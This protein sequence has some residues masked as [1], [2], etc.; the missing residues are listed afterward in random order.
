MLNLSTGFFKEEG[1]IAS[2]FIKDVVIKETEAEQTEEVKSVELEVSVVLAASSKSPLYGL[3]LHISAIKDAAYAN[4]IRVGNPSDKLRS[5]ILSQ[6]ETDKRQY[7]NVA[8]Q[9]HEPPSASSVINPNENEGTIYYSTVKVPM[10]ITYVG[11][12]DYLCLVA[13]VSEGFNSPSTSTRS[14]KEYFQDRQFIV[15]APS[16]ETVFTSGRPEIRTNIF[17]L[18]KDFEGYGKAGDVWPSAVHNHPNKGLMAGAVHDDKPHPALTSVRVPNL[19]IKDYRMGDINNLTGGTNAE[20]VNKYISSMYFSRSRNNML[21]IFFSFDFKNYVINNSTLSYAFANKNSLVAT[22]Q[23]QEIKIYRQRVDEGDYGNRLTPGKYANNTP[24]FDRAT[25]QLV[26]RLSD[27]SVSLIQAS[28]PP[29]NPDIYE[30][31]AIDS[32]IALEGQA[33]YQYSVEVQITDNS[34]KV[35]NDMTVA[36]RDKMSEFEQYI[37][38]FYNYDKKGY[39]VETYLDNSARF[40]SSNSLWKSVLIQYVSTLMF[41]K[42]PNISSHGPVLPVTRNLMA[43]V[44][45]TSATHS[46]MSRFVLQVNDFIR[47]LE[48][49]VG[50]RKVFTTRPYSDSKQSFQSAIDGTSALARRL[51]FN[52]VNKELYVNDLDTSTGFDYFDESMQLNQ[53][54]F[55]RISIDNY[56]TRISEE[57]NKYNIGNNN[58]ATVNKYGFLTPHAVRLPDGDISVQKNMNFDESLDLLR[59]K[60]EQLGRGLNISFIGAPAQED[61]KQIDV[62]SLLNLAGVSYQSSDGCIERLSGIITGTD[63]QGPSVIDSS[64]YFSNSSSFVID[65]SGTNRPLAED[66]SIA[67]NRKKKPTGI[68]SVQAVLSAVATDFR[69]VEPA[70]MTIAP[71]SYA[72]AAMASSPSN[73]SSLNIFEKNIKF[74]SVVG[75]EYLAGHSAN[76]REPIWTTLDGEAISFISNSNRSLLCRL[77]VPTNSLNTENIYELSMFVSLF[78]LGPG[79]LPARS[80]AQ[81]LPEMINNLKNFVNTMM[82]S[83][84]LNNGA[85]GG[86]MPSQYTCSDMMVYGAQTTAQAP[87]VA[88]AG[89]TMAAASMAPIT[90]GGGGY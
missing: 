19:K 43:M 14:F 64:F 26:A 40:G 11:D 29:I 41:F 42:G 44:S 71:G 28:R 90:T 70:P 3:N 79:I 49:L 8:L 47:Q 34:K 1:G 16:I 36:L 77:T 17:Q 12:I 45:P 83:G 9:D 81:A 53:K 58:L 31:I 52:F 27:G 30:I 25:K 57:I 37:L 10:T 20:E 51:K 15:S 72:A 84:M 22:N 2:P 35:V 33:R 86:A 56:G 13:V 75:V 85:A 65:E 76:T 50:Q 78:V 59:A 55:D 69:K 24:C 18:K 67:N 38:Q 82:S 4:S 66:A 6:F 23:I 80:G 73:F 7:T 89:S 88:A 60:K 21:K 32:D 48:N 62:E 63:T 5:L 61:V 46:S 39:D 74:N 68:E 87:A 54:T